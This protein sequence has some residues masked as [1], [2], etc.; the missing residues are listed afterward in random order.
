VNYKVLSPYSTFALSTQDQ[1]AKE[2]FQELASD[3]QR[4]VAMLNGRLNYINQ[5]NELN[6]QQS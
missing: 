2:M 3:A 6:K 4:H 1:T 5:S